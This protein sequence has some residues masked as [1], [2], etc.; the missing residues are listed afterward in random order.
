MNRPTRKRAHLLEKIALKES[1]SH[2]KAGKRAKRWRKSA[3]S[4]KAIAPLD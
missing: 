2:K 4:F 3:E 1:R